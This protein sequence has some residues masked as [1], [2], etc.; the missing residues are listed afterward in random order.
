MPQNISLRN[1]FILFVCFRVETKKGTAAEANSPPPQTNDGTDFLTNLV[2]PDQPAFDTFQQSYLLVS[3]YLFC[4]Y[5]K[6]EGSKA[7]AAQVRE[8]LDEKKKE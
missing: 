7:K 5:C 4:C 3:L 8:K 2:A 6:G 1:L